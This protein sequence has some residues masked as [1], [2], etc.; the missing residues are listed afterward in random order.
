MPQASD[1]PTTFHRLPDDFPGNPV[2]IVGTLTWGDVS[3]FP[4]ARVSLYSHCA[5]DTSTLSQIIEPAIGCI[6]NGSG[7]PVPWQLEGHDL[8]VILP[9][10]LDAE[11]QERLLLQLLDFV[12]SGLQL[13][14]ELGRLP[15][16]T[17]VMVGTMCG[18]PVFLRTDHQGDAFTEACGGFRQYRFCLPPDVRPTTEQLKL[19]RAA[20]VEMVELRLIFNHRRWWIVFGARGPYVIAHEAAR[21]IMAEH[22]WP[23]LA[24]VQENT[25]LIPYQPAKE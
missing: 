9:Q 8:T 10:Q 22:I 11:K 25:L 18:E 14:L 6:T 17:K 15:E 4:T 12:R 20:L 3:G 1:N 5:L 13:L 21:R 7:R 16:I 2:L 23:S 19:I 24:P